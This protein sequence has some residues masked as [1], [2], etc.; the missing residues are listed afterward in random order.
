M[1]LMRMQIQ[2]QMQM[3]I[4]IRMQKQMHANID[5]ETSTAMYRYSY[6]KYADAGTVAYTGIQKNTETTDADDGLQIQ[7][8]HI[9]DALKVQCQTIRVCSVSNWHEVV[10]ARLS[11]RE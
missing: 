10:V 6:K 2:M 5:T 11:T 9:C 1:H 4:Q 8:S 3:Q 7:I